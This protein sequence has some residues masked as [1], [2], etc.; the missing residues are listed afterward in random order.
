MKS[1]RAYVG[2]RLFTEVIA[3]WDLDDCNSN[4]LTIHHVIITIFKMKERD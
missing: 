2:I 4:V 3:V 1:I